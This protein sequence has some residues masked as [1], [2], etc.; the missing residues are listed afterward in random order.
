MQEKTLAEP[1]RKETLGGRRQDAFGA[2]MGWEEPPAAR[3]AMPGHA[4]DTGRILSRERRSSQQACPGPATGLQSRPGKDPRES[5]QPNAYQKATA[6]T[7][8]RSATRPKSSNE[9][10]MQPGTDTSARKP[11][12]ITR[13][14]NVQE[15]RVSTQG[16]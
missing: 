2:H 7:V 9:S 5:N 3:A 4:R 6:S 13:H 11:T 1:E 12:N 10:L 14:R 8:R 15:D 16:Q